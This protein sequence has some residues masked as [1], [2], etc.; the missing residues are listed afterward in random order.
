MSRCQQEIVISLYY[1]EGYPAFADLVVCISFRKRDI[2]PV[3]DSLFAYIFMHKHTHICMILFDIIDAC[4]CTRAE[5]YMVSGQRS[6]R[7]IT[8]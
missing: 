7:T 8:H 2:N 6:L 4:S 5:P 1:L 3:C